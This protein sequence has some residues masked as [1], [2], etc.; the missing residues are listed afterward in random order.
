MRMR[1]SIAGLM[2]FVLVAAVGFGGLKAA[3]PQWAGVCFSLTAATLILAILNAIHAQGKDRAYWAGFAIAGWAYLAIAFGPFGDGQG[4]RP[5][6]LTTQL[7]ERIEPLFH[8][9][10]PTVSWTTT[11]T[12]SL[13]TSPYPSVPIQLSAGVYDATIMQ[14]APP[15]PPATT[16]GATA[17]APVPAP[18]TLPITYFTPTTIAYANQTLPHFIQVGHSLAA[19]LAGMLGGLCSIW[20]FARRQRREAESAAPEVSPSSP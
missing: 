19:L 8:P 13:S 4:T 9:A 3:N 6:L 5:P 7:F 16:A 14:V 17:P 10:P 2:G 11:Y 1:F 15:A 12:T 18:A 20:L